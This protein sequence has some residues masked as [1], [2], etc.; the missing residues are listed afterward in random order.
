MYTGRYYS[1]DWIR[2]NVLR[3][4]DDDINAIDGEIKKERKDGIPM[5]AD[6]PYIGMEIEGSGKAAQSP[7]MT[8]AM[9]EAPPGSDS[10]GGGGDLNLKQ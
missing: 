5:P 1:M 4:N 8:A 7:T 2:R 10:A 9:P 3:L 6:V